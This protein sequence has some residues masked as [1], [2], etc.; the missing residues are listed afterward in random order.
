MSEVF[1]NKSVSLKEAEDQIIS[2]G[3]NATVHLMG[4]PGVGKTSM[5]KNIVKRTGFK[6]I[7][8][9]APNIELGELGIP[10]PD[11]STKTTR[12]YP[13]EQWGF[14]LDEPLVIFIDEFTKAHTAVKNMLHPMLNEPRQIM[15][16]PLHPQTIVVTAGNYTGDGV[17]DNMMAHSRNRISVMSV[18]KPHSGFNIDGSIDPDSWGEWAILNDVAPEVCAWVKEHPHVLASYLDPAQAG[19]KYI[20]NPKEAQ[21]SFVSPRSL[22]RASNIL[23]AR[24]GVTTNATVCALEGTIGAPAARDLMAFVEVADSLPRWEDIVKSPTTA[25]VPSSPAALCM[26]AFSAVQRVDRETIGKFFEYLKRTPKELQSVFCLTGMKNDDKKK[27]FLTSQSFVDWM[28]TN[29]YLF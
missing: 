23:K 26:L 24:A 29:Q 22:A 9:D 27:L 21:K 28:R 7:Y 4:E 8:I 15:G 20:F 3:A 11:H 6:G 13:N 17:G 16:I 1:M 10:I 2:L 19:N 5:F 12:M 14:H 25:Q 18:R